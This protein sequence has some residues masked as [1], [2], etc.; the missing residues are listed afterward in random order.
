[1]LKAIGCGVAADFRQLPA[2]LA[3]GRAEQAPQVRHRPLSGL[4][5]L[6]VGRQTAL[7]IGQI[8]RS[9]L[10]RCYVLVHG[11][12]EWFHLRHDASSIQRSTQKHDTKLAS[13]L[14]L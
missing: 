12:R 9:P 13:Q 14:Q 8:G 7:D 3:L 4:G 2:I 1:V 11:G 10:D 5:T 6:E